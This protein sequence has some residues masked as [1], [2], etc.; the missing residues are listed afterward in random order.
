MAHLRIVGITLGALL[1]AGTAFAQEDGQR[2]PQHHGQKP[3]AE[4]MAAWHA[5]MCTDHYAMAAARVAF[6]E[7][8]LSISAEQRPAFN[9]WRDVLLSDARA[10]QAACAAHTPEM[11][12]P[13]S[14]LDREAMA[15]KMLS[16]KLRALQAQRPALESLYQSLTP[17]QKI[18]FDEGE[19]HHMHR[20]GG[21]HDE[22]RHAHG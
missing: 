17:E 15:E 1:A 6:L 20:H 13:T 11:G 3:N 10:R 8:K 16:E 12:H 9:R 19:H 5:H 22:D 4:Q 2:G 18:A 21:G 14:A 7:A